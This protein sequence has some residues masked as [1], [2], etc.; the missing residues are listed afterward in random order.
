MRF[1]RADLPGLLIATL[2]PAGM[3]LLVVAGYGLWDHHGDPLLPTIA[4]HIAIGAGLM[5]A[6]TRFIKHWGLF[7]TLIGLLA[8][9]IA[10][11][12]IL[13]RTDNDGTTLA[14]SLKLAGVVLFLIINVVALR[15]IVWNGLGPVLERRD[16]RRAAEQQAGD[17]G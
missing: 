3:T 2:A 16:D 14:T 15:E 17:Q 7:G 4:V 6:L 1:K 8:V 11:V 10:A 5:A 13:Q 9:V 12:L